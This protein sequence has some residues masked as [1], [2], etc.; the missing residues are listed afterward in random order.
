MTDAHLSAITGTLFR[1]SGLTSLK[2]G[3][4]AGLSGLG[5]LT[6]YGSGIETL[7]VGL[8]DGLD[9]LGVLIVEVGL[10][11][12]PKDIFR[13]LGDTLN[14]LYL[15][16]NAI[17]GNRLAAGS[18]PDGVFESLTKLTTIALIGNPGFDSFRP[19]ADAGPGG[20]LTAGETVTLGGPGTS[21]GPWGSNVTHAWTQTDGADMAA[22]T[23]TLSATDVAKPD[24]HRA[25]GVGGDRCQDEAGGRRL[26]RRRSQFGLH[27]GIHD[28]GAGADRGGGDLEADCRL[29]LQA[30]RDH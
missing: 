3:D 15:S 17:P 13:G 19:T 30:G 21:G 20:T 24:L 25:D 2:L 8:F 27:G 26:G 16:G 14:G 10:T 4:F 5:Q 29:D 6:L 7:P 28:P 22:S 9:S 18:L 23:V 1:V 12:L 11:G